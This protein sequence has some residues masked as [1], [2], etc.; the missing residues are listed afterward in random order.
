M[1]EL[2]LNFT[3]EHDDFSLTIDEKIS[4]TGITGIFG[5]SGSGKSTLL[6]VIA[7][8][9]QQAHGKVLLDD[10]YLFNSEAKTFIAPHQRRIGLVFQNSRLFPHLNVEEN[11]RF[12]QKRHKNCRL[13][14]A[15]IVELT[16]LESL[17]YKA[18]TQLSGGEQQRVALARAILAEPR[19]LLLDEP[20][21]ALD[22]KN[23]II[24]L[25]LLDRVKR[26]L[27]LPMLYVS[28][29]LDELQQLADKLLVI[30]LGKVIHHGD[31]HHVIHQLTTN[32]EI[33]HQTSLSLMVKEHLPEYGLTSLRLGEQQIFIAC[34]SPSD[35]KK[36]VR[37]IIAASDISITLHEPIESSIVNH[38]HGEITAISH[39]ISSDGANAQMLITV[40]CS[41]Q[42]F[43]VTITTWSAKRLSLMPGQSI[44][45]QFKANAVRSLR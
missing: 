44:F 17:L 42:P 15:E 4:L 21:S 9:E 34:D 27:N 32:N 16:Q 23:K 39:I 11:L 33:L 38:L 22:D 43:F 25:A 1:A 40:N 35:K 8:L 37:C 3:V 5:H 20:L 10:E 29:S 6:K 12:G 30:S 28:H 13:S 45:I 31:I 14:F 18:V 36:K 24:L 26:K 41:A 7:G 2:A 19:L